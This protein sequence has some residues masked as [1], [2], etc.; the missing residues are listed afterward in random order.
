MLIPHSVD[1]SEAIRWGEPNTLTVFIR[2]A[3]NRLAG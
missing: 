2:S 1:I 3:M